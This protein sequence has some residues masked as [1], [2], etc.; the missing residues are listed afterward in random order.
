[1]EYKPGHPAEEEWQCITRTLHLPLFLLEHL[2]SA[3]LIMR[4]FY[5]GVI[6]NMPDLVK[7]RSRAQVTLSKEAVY[8]NPKSTTAGL[9]KPGKKHFDY[10]RTNLTIHLC[11]A[12]NIN[13]LKA[14]GNQVLK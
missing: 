14:F 3:V 4:N 11:A 5:I 8:K 7:L 12:E 2:L 9:R 13:R 6:Q 1:M 10:F